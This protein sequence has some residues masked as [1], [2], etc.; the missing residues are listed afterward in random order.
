MRLPTR[1][2]TVSF[3]KGINKYVHGG[4]FVCLF[5]FFICQNSDFYYALKPC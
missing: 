2:R 3:L 4:L 1:P 5:V